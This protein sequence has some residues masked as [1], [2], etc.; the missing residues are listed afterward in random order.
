MA[1]H[2]YIAVAND[3]RVRP[4]VASDAQTCAEKAV[5]S[6]NLEH[7]ASDLNNWDQQGRIGE[8]RHWR[9]RT[10]AKWW[11]YAHIHEFEGFDL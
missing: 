5:E 7:R 3:D 4:V 9:F 6:M 10:S 1:E 11:N 2:S 8:P